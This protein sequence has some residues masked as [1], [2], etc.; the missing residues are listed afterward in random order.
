MRK[1]YLIAG[2]VLVAGVVWAIYQVSSNPHFQQ[3]QSPGFWSTVSSANPYYLILATLFIGST[4]LLRALRWQ[5]MLRPTRA[6]NLKNVLV[7]TVIGFAIVGIVGRPGEFI[8]PF[9]IAKK[10]GVAVSSQIGAWT[11]ERI[12]DS[13]AIVGLLGASLWLWPPAI[14]AGT[15]ASS[16]LESFRRAGVVLLVMTIGLSCV[17][18]V[19]HYYPSIARNILRAMTQLL[20]DKFRANLRS[21]FDHF[22]SALAVIGDLPNLLLAL[23]STA[24]V[25]L[26]V[27]A[28]YWSAAQALGSPMNGINLG[29]LT[30]V[31]VAS[32]LGS[33]AHL[34]AV[35]GGIQLAT[36]L[37]LT[38]LFNVP[39]PV[40]SSMALFVWVITY[41]LVLIPGLPLAAR[42]G[43][44]WRSWSTLPQPSE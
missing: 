1:R 2:L 42:E 23:L 28:T 29:G 17:L 8:R 5:V 34:P 38:H 26:L 14:A 9:L 18:T 15:T 6:T 43:I 36:V 40:A 3:F 37:S 12:L 24:A 19:L 33:L 7:S 22:I 25:W 41:L 16:L 4:Y 35:G 10:E 27:L 39:V 44:T 30:L 13:L 11:L 20:P 21:I 31:M 32:G